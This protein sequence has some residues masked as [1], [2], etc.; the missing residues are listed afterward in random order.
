MRRP[1]A[2]ATGGGWRAW[3]IWPSRWKFP[4]KSWMA[5]PCSRW[6]D[7]RDLRRNGRRTQQENAMIYVQRCNSTV[8]SQ[9]ATVDPLV[10]ALAAHYGQMARLTELA[11]RFRGLNDEIDVVQGGRP[12]HRG[13]GCK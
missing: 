2:R 12:A 13:C 11:A 6:R 10:T 4:K 9:Y 3:S 5:F 1:A 8:F 7:F